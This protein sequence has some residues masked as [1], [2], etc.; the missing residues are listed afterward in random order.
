MV[1][2]SNPPKDSI[3]AALTFI[4]TSLAIYPLPKS[5]TSLQHPLFLTSGALIVSEVGQRMAG[6]INL[7]NIAI[8]EFASTSTALRVLALPLT[9]VGRGRNMHLFPD[10][11]MYET[12]SES[13]LLMNFRFPP[14][15]FGIFMRN[16]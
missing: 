2:R 11:I 3:G 12:V 5:I 8:V 14:F 13:K 6:R 15:L 10:H 1:S 7:Y 9:F 4:I 16:G